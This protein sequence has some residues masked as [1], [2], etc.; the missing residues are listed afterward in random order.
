MAG[1]KVPRMDLLEKK[2][3]PKD[4]AFYLQLEAAS[5]QLSFSAYSCAF[6]LF[7]L[8][9]VIDFLTYHENRPPLNWGHPNDL[10]L[11]LSLLLFV[12]PCCVVKC[13]LT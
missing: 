11:S 8:C 12:F 13:V 6:E 7:Y 2:K 5:L 1:G 9:E 10:S 3:G 4:A